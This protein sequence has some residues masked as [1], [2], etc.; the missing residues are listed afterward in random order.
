MPLKQLNVLAGRALLDERF[1]QAFF[2]HRDSACLAD[3]PLT[4]EER[5][6]ILTTSLS[7]PDKLIWDLWD[8][9]RETGLVIEDS[10]KGVIPRQIMFSRD[11]LRRLSA[12]GH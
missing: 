9:A 4:D 12:D 6:A 5:V 10:T 8:F 11:G 2:G 1:Q 7:G 3:V